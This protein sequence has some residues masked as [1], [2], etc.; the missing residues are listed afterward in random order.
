MYFCGYHVL[1]NGPNWEY[2]SIISIL[3]GHFGQKW[4]IWHPGVPLYRVP[5]NYYAIDIDNIAS[6][7]NLNVL[8][9]LLCVIYW[10]N[11]EDFSIISIFGVIFGQN[12]GIWP[13]GVI[14]VTH[15][16]YCLV[17]CSENTLL[18]FIFKLFLGLFCQTKWYKLRSY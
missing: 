5:P 4:G 10:P 7:S 13:P 1:S 11:W 8:V 15:T 9:W 17:N 2:F 12:C 16:S 6:R 14:T 3:G 18:L